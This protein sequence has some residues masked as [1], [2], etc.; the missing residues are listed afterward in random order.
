VLFKLVTSINPEE[1]IR[2]LEQALSLYVDSEKLSNT[3]YSIK[4]LEPQD[5]I[6]YC[7]NLRA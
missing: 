1:T 6:L 5:G 4:I 3:I 2:D 7:S